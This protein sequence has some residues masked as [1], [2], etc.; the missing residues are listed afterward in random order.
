MT[1]SAT[2]SATRGRMFSYTFLA[3]SSSPPKRI[4][5]N[6]VSTMPGLIAVTRMGVPARSCLAAMVNA[7]TAYF[8]AQYPDPPAYASWPAT[9][10]MFT[11]WPRLRA[12]IPGPKVLTS[13]MTPRTLVLSIVCTSSMLFS[14]AADTPS[15]RPALFTRM[16]TSGMPAASRRPGKAFTAATSLTSSCKATG[17]GTP[18]KRSRSLAL[19]ASSLSTR[20]P[21]STKRQPSSANRQAVASPMPAVAPVM[22]TGTPLR[23]MGA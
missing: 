20:R 18:G 23:S 7:F 15:A 5:E 17:C 19:S 6:S 8:V 11:M 4:T 3:F 21:V 16:S 9:D 1:W 22:R 10:E 2:S 13:A 14:S 12:R